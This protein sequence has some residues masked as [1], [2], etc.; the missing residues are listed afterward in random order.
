MYSWLGLPHER[1]KRGG[2]RW[3]KIWICRPSGRS[4]FSLVTSSAF[5]LILARAQA[6]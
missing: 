3:S 6:Q 5:E 1:V 2:L 4:E